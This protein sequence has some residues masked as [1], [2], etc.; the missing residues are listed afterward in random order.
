MNFIE[1][2][3]LTSIYKWKY[4][5]EIE[6]RNYNS[7]LLLLKLENGGKINKNIKNSKVY[8]HIRI[9]FDT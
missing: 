5:L 9:N 1:D 7:N 4:K 6:K 3:N 2:M 8:I